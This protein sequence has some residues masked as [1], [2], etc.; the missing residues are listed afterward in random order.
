MI[1]IK[2]PFS[3]ANFYEGI[4]DK[5]RNILFFD[6]ETT[7]LNR[8]YHTIYL[9]GAATRRG[10]A[11]ELVQWLSEDPSEE[12]DVIRAFLSYARGY[13]TLIHFNGER[14]DLPFTKARAEKLC[15]P[16]DLSFTESIDLMK[17]IKPYKSLCALENCKQKTIEKLLGISSR[18]DVMT[19]GEL[20]PVYEDFVKTKDEEDLT[21]LLLHNA[22]DVRCMVDLTAVSKFSDFF[23]GDFHLKEQ[24]STEEGLVFHFESS[25]RLPHLGSLHSPDFQLVCAGNQLSLI[26]VPFKGSLKY[27]YP[28]PKN[29][30]YLPDEDLVVHKSVAQFVD[31]DHKKKCTKENCFVKR[32]G[33]FLPQAKDTIKPVFKKEQKDKRYYFLCEDGE[34][35]DD[36]FALSY[37][38]EILHQVFKLI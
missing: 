19:G 20:I 13:D 38:K 22:D 23:H 8:A 35:M 33:F 18:E 7:G 30:F 36:A 24:M 6:I 5:D 26:A 34:G 4:C 9:I 27:F 12:G 21:L 10:D 37:L 31:K 17:L 11:W 14:F 16:F 32:E 15:I 28:D 1:T 3:P 25:V 29:Y 2:E